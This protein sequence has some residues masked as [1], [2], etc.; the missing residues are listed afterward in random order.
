MSDTE[1]PHRHDRRR[2]R[3]HRRRQRSRP[4]TPSDSEEYFSD[5]ESLT[6]SRGAEPRRHRRS[7][8]KAIVLRDP[9]QLQAPP[10][11]HRRNDSDDDSV[12]YTIPRDFNEERERHRMERE[13][14]RER[15]RARRQRREGGML[16]AVALFAASAVFCLDWCG[17]DD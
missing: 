14:E 11:A 5:P 7:D 16:I 6:S 9:Y 2:H 3:H 13:R 1:A 4:P 17:N 15:E 10:R 12:E 8:S